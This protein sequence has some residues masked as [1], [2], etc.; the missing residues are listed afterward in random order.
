MSL[1][2][3]CSRAIVVRN[4]VNCVSPVGHRGQVVQLSSWLA[5]PNRR[6]FHSSADKNTSNGLLE[7]QHQRRSLSTPAAGAVG[8]RD[9]LDT[10]FSD[11]VAAFKSKTLIELIRA[12]AVYM[13]CSSSYLV[14][15]NMKVGPRL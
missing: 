4:K 15:N 3:F 12:Y 14:E 9:P 6:E 8:Q 13:I 10:G 11:P 2:R 1:V 7:Q 5:S